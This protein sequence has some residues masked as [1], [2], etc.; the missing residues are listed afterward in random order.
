[1]SQQDFDD[2]WDKNLPLSSIPWWF[3]GFIV[4]SALLVAL[5]M[6]YGDQFEAWVETYLF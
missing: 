2:G 4:V 3:A 1:M 5:L 6:K